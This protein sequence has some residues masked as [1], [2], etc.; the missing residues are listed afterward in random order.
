MF[1]APWA[2]PPLEPSA[3]RFRARLPDEAGRSV[4]R[5]AGAPAGHRGDEVR[6]LQGRHRCQNQTANRSPSGGAKK[7]LW[8]FRGGMAVVV[9]TVLAAH[10]RTYFSGWSGMFTGGT[11]WIFKRSGE[12]GIAIGWKLQQ[13]DDIFPRNGKS[14][15]WYF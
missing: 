7:T 11:I 3:V 6:P 15:P 5:H 8:S 2:P 14:Y 12:R 9:K 4:R 1:R 10:F 13:M